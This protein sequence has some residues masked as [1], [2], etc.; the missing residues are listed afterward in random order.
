MQNNQLLTKSHAELED[1]SIG[2]NLSLQFLS[3]KSRYSALTYM[4][5]EISVFVSTAGF[6]DS[7]VKGYQDCLKTFAT[8]FSGL[9]NGFYMLMLCYNVFLFCTAGAHSCRRWFYIS[10]TRGNPTT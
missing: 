7:S 3:W 8:L 2:E 6:K 10:H 4:T 1:S 9:E 5:C